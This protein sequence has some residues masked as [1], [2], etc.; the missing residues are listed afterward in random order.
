MFRK[1]IRTVFTGMS[2]ERIILRALYV[3]APAL[4]SPYNVVV[5]SAADVKR[6]AVLPLLDFTSNNPVSLYFLI[7]FSTPMADISNN[8][9][10]NI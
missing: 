2:K 5:T 3:C 10:N 1:I 7:I 6:I 8:H 9:F 4:V